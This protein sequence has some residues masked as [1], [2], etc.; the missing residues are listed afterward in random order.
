MTGRAVFLDR[1]GVINRAVV[2]DGKPYPP[3]HPAELEILP[4]VSS[5]LTR[6]RAAGFWL[7]VVTNQPDVARGTQTQAEVENLH[8][9]LQ[10]QLPLDEFR[11]CYHDDADRC[12]CRKPKPGLLLAAA[13]EHDLD[14]SASFMIGDRWRDVEAGQR[15][16]C[17]TLFVDYGY[18]ERAPVEPFIKVT[19][20][21]AAADWILQPA[22]H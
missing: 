10:A 13:R 2:R 9:V 11:V 1:D 5:A 16:G 15:A 3:S 18:A 8:A 20:L 17:T 7:I 21:L 14:L 6:L 22:G 4:G 12:D 19:S